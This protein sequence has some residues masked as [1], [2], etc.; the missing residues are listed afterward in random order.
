MNKKKYI[1]S[2]QNNVFFS[3]EMFHLIA[4]FHIVFIEIY[5]Q[6]HV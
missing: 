4:T 6:S 2:I 5:W 3:I 1:Q